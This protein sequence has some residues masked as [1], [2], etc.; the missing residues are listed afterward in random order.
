MKDKLDPLRGES[1]TREAEFPQI[2]N[3]AVASQ[4][5]FASLQRF[6]DGFLI[7]PFF[8]KLFHLRDGKRLT[9]IERDRSRK[10]PWKECSIG[11]IQT[12]V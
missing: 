2:G 11:A 12:A 1:V 9:G 7:A 4:F 5:I 10:K 6:S 3:K 8:Q